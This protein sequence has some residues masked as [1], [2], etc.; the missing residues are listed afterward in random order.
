MAK[1]RWSDT[2]FEKKSKDLPEIEQPNYA[3][4]KGWGYEDIE[5]MTYIPL[6]AYNQSKVANVL[7]S[8]ALNK[9]LNEKYGI[10]SLALHPGVIKTE[11]GRSAGPEVLAAVKSMVDNQL[12]TYKTLGAG[13]S[14]SLVAA[15]DPGLGVGEIKDGKEN[16][17]VFLNNCQIED[18]AGPLAVSS[19]EAERLWVLSQELVKQKFD[20]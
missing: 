16:Y 2:N 13:A 7:F 8:I 19:S 11:L 17:G 10:L 12:F 14:T 6:E 5:E 3:A 4:L 18:K 15:L 9:R 20:W 1:M